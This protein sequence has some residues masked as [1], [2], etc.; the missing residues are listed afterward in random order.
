[1][2]L[3][4]RA[5]W[6]LLA[7]VGPLFGASAAGA[8][9]GPA[10]A[11][12]RAAGVEPTREGLEKF[13]G[14]MLLT[15]A[16][17]ARIRSWL[18]DLGSEDFETRE[19]ASAEL[20]ALPF[21]PR[22][23]LE[24][25]AKGDLETAKR[26]EQILQ[27]PARA[28]HE[29]KV[30]LALQAVEE[31]RLKGLASLLL[32]LLPQWPE[33][34]LSE[35]AARALAAT[36]ERADGE[37]LK[38]ALASNRP[39]KARA[40]AATA[41]AAAL[42]RDAERELEATLGDRDHAVGMAAAVALLNQGSRKP[43]AAL[44]RWLDAEQA[45]VRQ[46]AVTVLLEV[47][48]QQ[49]DY[50]P[51][52]EPKQRAAGVAAWREWV[53]RHGDTA[54]LRLPVGAR[55]AFRGRVVVAVWGERVV[56]EID[57]RS[58]KTVFEVGGLTYPWGAHATP[59][60][61]RLAVDYQQS[62]VV[63]Y[64]GQGKEVWRQNVPGSPTGV[65][66]LPDGR[67]L[68]AL[69]NAGKVVEIDRAG[70]VVWEL[71]LP[72]LPTTATRLP[73]G[74]TMVS[75]QDAG[76]VVAL[77]RRGNVVWQVGGMQRPHT[78]QMLPNGNVL[79]CEFGEGVIKEYDRAGKVVWTLRGVNNPAQAQRLPDGNTLVSGAEGLMEFDPK[80]KMLR[81]FKMNRLRFFAY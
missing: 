24:G 22:S 44:A 68:L 51:Y 16:R 7:L 80:G 43:L 74:N 48:G 17:E 26:V 11:E 54:E 12:L 15:P 37:A 81:H 67:T 30:F 10:A 45:D 35:A 2:S 52:D 61:R 62:F 60:G 71:A 3:L 31:G 33:E 18:A 42:G 77:D 53:A 8:E 46:A 14:P 56:R 29:R 65:Q 59:D 25:A 78:A 1:M 6:C 50:A 76:K 41:L 73:D 20:A 72:G 34:H 58:G 57:L 28:E 63:E 38:A 49:I 36:A 47:S 19:K 70:K 79:V 39:G 32:G 23:L 9:P 4:R 55:P 66:R 13:L 21:L 75:L 64:D 5:G 40:A 69:S 27:G